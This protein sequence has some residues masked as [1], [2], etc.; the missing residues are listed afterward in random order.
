MPHNS[1]VA[2]NRNFLFFIPNC[3]YVHD[4]L[5]NGVNL[6]HLVRSLGWE[7]VQKKSL[8]EMLF[9]LVHFCRRECGSSDWL[10]RKAVVTMATN[11][12]IDRDSRDS[13]QR[14]LGLL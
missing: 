1:E 2:E 8:S 14:Q 12:Q 9:D 11:S 3:S 7:A 5:I 13:A 10:R 6:I 4:L